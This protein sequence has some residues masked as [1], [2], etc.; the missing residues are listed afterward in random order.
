MGCRVQGAG[1][2]VYSPPLAAASRP[3]GLT[4]HVSLSLSFYVCLSHT[5][6]HSFSVCLSHTH[7][8]THTHTHT[9]TPKHKQSLSLSLTLTHTL[10]ARGGSS[11]SYRDRPASG[12]NK[13]HLC[14]LRMIISVQSRRR[15][16][17]QLL[18]DPQVLSRIMYLFISVR[19]QPPHKTFHLIF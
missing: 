10:A 2:W 19:S 8:H 16:W 12:E 18:H 4:R 6:I 9:H 5:H 7:I 14:R 15:A 13:S 1:C 17:G 3:L 11:G